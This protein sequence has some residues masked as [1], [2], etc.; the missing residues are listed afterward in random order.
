LLL[1]TIIS[2]IWHRHLICQI[3]TALYTKHLIFFN[4]SSTFRTHFLLHDLHFR[5]IGIVFRLF[6]RF[7]I[8]LGLR[9]LCQTISTLHA[10]NLTF[11]YRCSA[12]WTTSA[13]LWRIHLREG[14]PYTAFTA[15]RGIRINHS[16]TAGTLYFSFQLLNLVLELIHSNGDFINVS[17]HHFCF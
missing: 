7:Q 11:F 1:L 8:H 4:G 13:L 2:V 15:K 14:N 17:F 6:Y 16:S 3:L 12:T 5:H 10:K 9:Y